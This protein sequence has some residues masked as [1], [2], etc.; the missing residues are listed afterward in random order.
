MPIN[1]KRWNIIAVAADVDVDVGNVSDVGVGVVA[2]AAHV[3]AFASDDPIKQD[4][5]AAVH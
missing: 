5:S 1:D 3:V 4:S 2:A